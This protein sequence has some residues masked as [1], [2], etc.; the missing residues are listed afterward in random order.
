MPAGMA[1]GKSTL[2]RYLFFLHV[3]QDPAHIY[4]RLYFRS[5]AGMLY[6]GAES[7]LENR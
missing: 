3:Y 7:G 2:F 6:S 1:S 5:F 4:H